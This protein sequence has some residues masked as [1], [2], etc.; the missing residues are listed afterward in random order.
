M[1]E[2]LDVIGPSLLS[3]LRTLVDADAADD[4]LQDTYVS[5]CR[6]LRWLREPSAYR[7]WCF[8]IASRNAYR[9]LKRRRRWS[10]IDVSLETGGDLEAESLNALENATLRE[11]IAELPPAS[12]AALWLHYVDGP[13]L[14][15]LSEVLEIPV[16]TVK[17]RVAYGL[18]K[19]R[20]RLNVV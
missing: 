14:I 8:R 5:I 17:S 1:S 18:Q 15:E 13:T 7:A 11:I 6:K 16:G 4:L 12:K 2:L 3:Y 9:H 19:I 10:E 20:A